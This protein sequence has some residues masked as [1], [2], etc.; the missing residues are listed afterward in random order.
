MCSFKAKF[1]DVN[2][3]L[4]PRRKTV[5]LF[6]FIKKI[7]SVLSGEYFVYLFDITMKNMY[8]EFFYSVIFFCVLNTI[9]FNGQNFKSEFYLFVG[10]YKRFILACFILY[11]S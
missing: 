5:S 11:I 8:K 6:Y 3:R 2:C 10:G 1:K 7:K 9:F 4:L